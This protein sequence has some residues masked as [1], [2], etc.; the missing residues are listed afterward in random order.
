MFFCGYRK[1][2]NGCFFFS[3]IYFAHREINFGGRGA[4]LARFWLIF[5]LFLGSQIHKNGRKNPK[6]Q[7]SPFLTLRRSGNPLVVS[8]AHGKYPNMIFRPIWAFKLFTMFFR[9]IMQKM[10]KFKNGKKWLLG[11]KNL[12]KFEKCQK[13]LFSLVKSPTKST[14]IFLPWY[15]GVFTL[16]IKINF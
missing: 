8:P 12:E 15:G 14:D 6:S 3:Y 1:V 9:Q 2:P 4:I 10:L 7:E 11:I 13:Y 16:Q 5:W